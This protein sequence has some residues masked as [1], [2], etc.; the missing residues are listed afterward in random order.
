MSID[1]KAFHK[2]GYGLY[3]LGA[4]DAAGRANACII[5]TFMQLA[6]DPL[7]VSIAVGKSGYTHEIISSTGNFSI[8][9]LTQNTP[10]SFFEAFGM[11]T[12]RNGEKYEALGECEYDEIFSLPYTDKFANARFVCRV[13]S[14]SDYG[15]HTHN[16]YGRC[17]GKPRY[18]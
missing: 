8:S 5:N 13:K 12:G 7:T 16:S 10:Y 14:S 17:G 18:R 11:Q 3:L 2:I 4:K 1:K 6:S 9:V 15:S